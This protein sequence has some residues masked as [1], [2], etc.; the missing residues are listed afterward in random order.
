MA[1]Q[2]RNAVIYTPPFY[3]Q[4][5]EIKL[6]SPLDLVVGLELVSSVQ[7]AFQD[8]QALAAHNLWNLWMG[9]ELRD[10]LPHLIV[11]AAFTGMCVLPR[12]VK[13]PLFYMQVLIS[14]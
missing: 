8:S 3:I 10:V 13:S 2:Q 6:E 9:E 11:N 5:T 14:I 1:K 7:T 12:G 4:A